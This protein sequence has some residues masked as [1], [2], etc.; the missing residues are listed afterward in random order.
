MYNNISAHT[1]RKV[2]KFKKKEKIGRRV[3]HGRSKHKF[4][5]NANC[6]YYS[7]FHGGIVLG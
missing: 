7:Y 3:R 1:L 6:R 4:S 5:I 2:F